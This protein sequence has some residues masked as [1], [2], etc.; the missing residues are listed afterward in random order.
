MFTVNI[1]N[2]TTSSVS[3]NWGNPI[4]SDCLKLKLIFC[5]ESGCIP[6]GITKSIQIICCPIEEV[7]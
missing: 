7:I 4:G 6:A 1:K 3:Y 5:C 2:M